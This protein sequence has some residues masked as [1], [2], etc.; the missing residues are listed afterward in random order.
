MVFISG[1]ILLSCQFQFQAQEKPSVRALS[2]DLL[3]ANDSSLLELLINFEMNHQLVIDV[4]VKVKEA[5][6]KG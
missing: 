1:W 5:F 4:S 6:F 3:S 2:Q